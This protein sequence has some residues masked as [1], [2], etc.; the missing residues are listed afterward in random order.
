MIDEDDLCADLQNDGLICWGSS[1]GGGSAAMGSGAPWDARSW[2]A[3]SWFLR[4]WWILIGGAEGEI[5]KQ[6]RWW[7]EM[8][9]ERF[10]NPW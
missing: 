8:R 6:T 2:E 10:C 4:K 1:L 9:G 5:Y 7:C 3:Q